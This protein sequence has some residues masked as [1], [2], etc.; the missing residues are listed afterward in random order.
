MLLREREPKLHEHTAKVLTNRAKTD[1]GDQV[2]AAAV[3]RATAQLRPG[4]HQG[5]AAQPR[6]RK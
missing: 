2:G 3:G 1:A 5:N 6:R 4:S